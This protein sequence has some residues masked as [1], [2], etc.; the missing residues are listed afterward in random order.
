MTAQNDFVFTN[1]KLKSVTIP[2]KLV[3]NLIIIKVKINNI[4]L[5]LILDTG[6]KQTLLLNLKDKNTD[7][8]QNL[9]KTRFVGTGNEKKSIQA[10]KTINNSIKLSDLII[11]KNANLYYITNENFNF[12]ETLGIPVYGFIGG[13]LLNNFVVKIDYSRK[14]IKFYSQADFNYKKIRHYHKIPIK[15]SSNKPFI[16]TKIKFGKKSEEIPVKLLIDTGNSDALW[17]FENGNLK[18]PKKIKYIKDYFGLGF[19]G[20]IQGKRIKLY[21]LKLSKKIKF[22]D[23]YTALPD[24]IYFIDLIRKN[25]FDGI[26]GSE[27]LNRFKL[28]LDYKN[29]AIYLKKNWWKYHNEFLFND[30]GMNLVYAGKIPVKVRKTITQFD[31]NAN[32]NNKNTVVAS[33][34]I[35][36]EYKFVDRIIINYIRPDSP[37][38]KAGFMVGDVLLSING[39]SVYNYKLNELEKKFFYKTGKILKFV[40]IRKGIELELKLENKKQL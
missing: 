19:N 7:K 26:I 6:I 35:I 20:E 21:D 38:Y 28:I 34:E 39:N 3:N 24:S 22:R 31:E 1:Q 27:I 15:L 8:Y 33:T 11:S 37:A 12:S 14:K 2:F 30:S 18:L 32:F 36:Y 23:V 16:Q 17:L 9:K 5:N 13:D 4:P 40:I 25:K 29:K 10:V